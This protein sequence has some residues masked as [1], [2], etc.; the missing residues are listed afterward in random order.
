MITQGQSPE[1]VR[2]L[3]WEHV[4]DPSGV[5]AASLLEDVDRKEGSTL[6]YRWFTLHSWDGAEVEAKEVV[7][8]HMDHQLPWVICIPAITDGVYRW[9]NEIGT[10]PWGTLS[11]RRLLPIGQDCPDEVTWD[12]QR[13]QAGCPGLV[14]SCIRDTIAVIKYLLADRRV[15]TFHGRPRI[16]AV[17]ECQGAR[18]AWMSAAL[19]ETIGAVVAYEGVD[20]LE[21][22]AQAGIGLDDSKLEPAAAR[23][24][25]PRRDFMAALIPRPLFLFHDTQH[26]HSGDKQR[27]GYHEFVDQLRSAYHNAHA[28]DR[29]K[30]DVFTHSKGGGDDFLSVGKPGPARNWLRKGLELGWW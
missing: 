4:A 9:V 26:C 5:T 24:A 25:V 18:I 30:V 7:P 2:R 3:L 29:L 20:N 13:Q 23:A 10:G 1:A 16:A 8:K 17:G 12:E 14:V 27:P 19:D 22:L 11:L 6:K 21:I 28:D 15:A